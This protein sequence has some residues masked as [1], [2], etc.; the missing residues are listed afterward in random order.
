MEKGCALEV[1][2]SCGP[3]TALNLGRASPSWAFDFPFWVG[4]HLLE[5][6][7]HLQAKAFSPLTVLFGLCCPSIRKTEPCLS[8]DKIM[9]P[10]KC[11]PKAKCSCRAVGRMLPG[12]GPSFPCVTWLGTCGHFSVC[13][14]PH[15]P[16]GS[17]VYALV[18]QSHSA[19]FPESR[20]HLINSTANM[21]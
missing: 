15:L 14:R 1:G 19:Y 17:V 10:K 2:V 16:Q 11:L 12:L 4:N 9:F 5:G 13:P 21:Y 3:A 18:V 7:G 8:L 20:E 6:M